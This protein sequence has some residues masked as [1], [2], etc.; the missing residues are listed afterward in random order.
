[1]VNHPFC[2]NEDIVLSVSE[3]FG[4]NPG[5]ITYTYKDISEYPAVTLGTQTSSA[6][7]N[8]FTLSPSNSNYPS[9]S[10]ILE[11]DI[12]QQSS[13]KT[14]KSFAHITIIPSIDFIPPPRLSVCNEAI[15]IQ[16]EGADQKGSDGFIHYGNYDFKSV[17]G[18]NETLLQSGTNPKY[19]TTGNLANGNSTFKVYGTVASDDGSLQCPGVTNDAS[20]TINRT[21]SDPTPSISSTS[22]SI[23]LGQCIKLTASTSG[24]NTSYYQWQEP[25]NGGLQALTGSSVIAQPET[26]GTFN[27]T[28]NSI[29]VHDNSNGCCGSATKTITVT[30]KPNLCTNCGAFQ[31][32]TGSGSY[33]LNATAVS[34]Y[35][36][37]WVMNGV[38][39]SGET[40]QNYTYHNSD[41]PLSG[42]EYFC[43][44]KK[45]FSGVGDCSFESNH[46]IVSYSGICRE[47]SDTLEYNSLENRIICSVFPNPND[48]NFTLKLKS[49]KTFEGKVEFTLSDCSMRILWS[50]EYYLNGSEVVENIQFKSKLE[51]GIYFVKCLANADFIVKP[52]IIQ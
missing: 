26:E 24:T 50:K 49:T 14:A 9:D 2:A 7:T 42:A 31:I 12:Y 36:Y 45:T 44:Y 37:Q 19:S 32:C 22:G 5:S 33:T 17:N 48:G 40:N 30:S 47:A 20:I 39:I 23:F 43:R 10:F 11:V 4:L 1:M 46:H 38:E 13:Q 15:T 29:N 21:G 3:P 52:I 28:V 16:A 35:T 8:T 25:A 6:S 27:Y 34:G 51:P 41:I 18:G